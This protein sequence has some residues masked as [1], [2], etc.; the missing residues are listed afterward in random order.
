MWCILYTLYTHLFKYIARVLHIRNS[1]YFS[2]ELLQ[3][4]YYYCYFRLFVICHCHIFI[5]NN[6]CILIYYRDFSLSDLTFTDKK[7]S[8]SWLLLFYVNHF[9]FANDFNFNCTFFECW[10]RKIICYFFWFFLS[11]NTYHKFLIFLKHWFANLFTQYDKQ[12][13]EIIYFSW[14]LID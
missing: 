7:G 1:I 6:V 10:F 2:A 13:Y 11:N 3:R 5:C 4:F 14:Q 9:L 8:F 12:L